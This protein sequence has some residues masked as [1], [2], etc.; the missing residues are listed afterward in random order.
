M[1]V[2]IVGWYGTETLGDRAILDEVYI[3]SFLKEPF[4]RIEMHF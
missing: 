2:C 1:N 4:L 3:L